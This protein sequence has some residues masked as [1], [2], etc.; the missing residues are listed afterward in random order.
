MWVL[1]WGGGAR[2]GISL[3]GKEAETDRP[4]AANTS[5]II[6]MRELVTSIILFTF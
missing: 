2:V 3:G 4:S 6:L 1:S 5:E